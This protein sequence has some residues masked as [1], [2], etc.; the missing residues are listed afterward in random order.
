MVV[1]FL[2]A[3]LLIAIVRFAAAARSRL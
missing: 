2:G 3:C 1:A